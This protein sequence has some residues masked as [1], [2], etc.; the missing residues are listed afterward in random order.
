M[1][2][3]KYIA[4]FNFLGYFIFHF[5]LGFCNYLK[6]AFIVCM[7]CYR[8]FYII[9]SKL[10]SFVSSLGCFIELQVTNCLNLSEP[11]AFLGTWDFSFIIWT[12]VGK[13]RQLIALGLC[14]F[15]QN[16]LTNNRNICICKCIERYKERHKLRKIKEKD[17]RHIQGEKDTYVEATDTCLCLNVCIF[18][19]L[20]MYLYVCPSI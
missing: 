16:V 20:Y 17:E 14:T 6:L 15:K 7:N 13:L 9:T 8:H 2:F 4:H 3:K 12:A 5:L 19:H 11:D 10:F 18:L 1:I